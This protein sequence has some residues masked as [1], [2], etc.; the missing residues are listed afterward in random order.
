MAPFLW[1]FLLA[2]PCGA[3]AIIG[4]GYVAASI[5]WPSGA[6]RWAWL[7]RGVVFVAI[8]TIGF[9]ILLVAGVF[10]AMRLGR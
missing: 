10:L 1:A 2:L 6:R 3:A 8:A 4:A 5:R 7:L 9:V